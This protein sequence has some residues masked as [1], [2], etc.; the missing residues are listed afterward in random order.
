MSNKI[1]FHQIT[2]KEYFLD[3][4]DS[5]NFDKNKIHEQLKRDLTRMI[6]NING[7]EIK[8][9]QQF[10]KLINNLELPIIYK[11]M[12]WVLPT[13]VSMVYFYFYLQNYYSKIK[14]TYVVAELGNS[15]KYSNDF[16]INVT[17]TNNA[18]I[19]IHFIK[20]FR[21]LDTGISSVPAI[22]NIF[23]EVDIKIGSSKMVLFRW[24]EITA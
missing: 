24:K 10:Y 18:F 8:S 7:I 17:I 23:L 9:I 19:D 15:N 16:I 11:R 12:I 14:N 2:I 21:V 5:F 3:V 6:I 22:Y 13:Q 20:N 4:F 1:N